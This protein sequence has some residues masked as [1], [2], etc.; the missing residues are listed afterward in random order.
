MAY[1]NGYNECGWQG[2]GLSSPR[3]KTVGFTWDKGKIK[4]LKGA[5]E[6]LSLTD[7]TYSNFTTMRIVAVTTCDCGPEIDNV[8]AGTLQQTRI[9]GDANGDGMVDVGDLGILAANYGGTGKTWAEGD[10]NDDRI[11]D[12]G[13]LGILAANYGTGT[14]GAHFEVDYAKIFRPAIKDDEKANNDTGSDSC[15]GLGL[16]LIAGLILMGVMMSVKQG[17]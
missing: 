16:S 6:A 9:A 11:V 4:V 13:D 14:S 7:I 10:F 3:W 8:M 12:V 17:E 15:S 2:M 1:G 5:E